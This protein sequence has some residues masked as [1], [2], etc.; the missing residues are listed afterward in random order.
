MQDNR[1]GWLEILAF[2]L[3]VFLVLLAALSVA[4]FFFPGLYRAGGPRLE[5]SGLSAGEKVKIE[6]LPFAGYQFET[7]VDAN[8]AVIFSNLPLGDWKVVE[9]GTA[10]LKT[11]VMPL[12]ELMGRFTKEGEEL[13]IFPKGN[14][15]YCIKS[16]PRGW[17]RISWWDCSAFV[18]HVG[19]NKIQVNF[20]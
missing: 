7:N 2:R 8:G 15:W 12:K 5:I 20:D 14:G 3:F 13:R 18:K 6:K 10:A 19:R 9:G 16:K 11:V 4:S 1:P 17:W